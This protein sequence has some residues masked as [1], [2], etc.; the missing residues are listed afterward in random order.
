MASGHPV[1]ASN[2]RA[3]QAAPRLSNPGPV[4]TRLP[5]NLLWCALA[6]SIT[7]SIVARIFCGLG[8]GGIIPPSL[9]MISNLIHVSIPRSLPSRSFLLSNTVLEICSTARRSSSR[10]I[11]LWTSFVMVQR[12]WPKWGIHWLTK[13]EASLALRARSKDSSTAWP[14]FCSTCLWCASC[15]LSSSGNRNC[16]QS[17]S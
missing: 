10:W 11:L 1:I 5:P 6:G 4:F 9:V 16:H 13:A 12:A 7:S 8:R 3:S 15:N 2:S 17:L 14:D